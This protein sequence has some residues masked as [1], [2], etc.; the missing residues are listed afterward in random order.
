MSIKSRLYFLIA[1]LS[2][3]LLGI[4]VSGV[5]NLGSVNASLKTVYEDRLICVGQL[6]H[7]ARS[8]LRAQLGLSTV[9]V[10]DA[11]G[12]AKAAAD[13]EALIHDADEQWK[14]YAATYLTSDGRSWSN[15]MRTTTRSS[16]TKRSRRR[17]QHCAPGMRSV[18]MRSCVVR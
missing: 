2:V 8:L 6:D 17:W 12:I 4:G 18:S 7:M 11:A 5:V 16:A 13:I 9:D 10:S 1:L 3:L 15:N 14:A